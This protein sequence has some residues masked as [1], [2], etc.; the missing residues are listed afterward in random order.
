MRLIIALS[1]ISLLLAPSLSAVDIS[2][3][4]KHQAKNYGPEYFAAIEGEV[5]GQAAPGV[6]AVYINGKKIPV[7]VDLS[8]STTIALKKGQKYLSVETRYKG[9]RFIKKYL[10]IRHP[11]IT[12]PFKIRVSKKEFEKIIAQSKVVRPKPVATTAK[13]KVA[14]PKKKKTH[15]SRKKNKSRPVPRPTPMPEPEIENWLGFEFV[16]ELEPGKLLIVRKVNKKYY[17]AMYDIKTSSWQS[18]SEI[19]AQEFQDLLKKSELL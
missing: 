12:E 15:I 2:E 14:Q 1:L 11:K 13:K 18:L 17:A 4:E 9:L 5:N 6:E 16:A 8:F 10:V 19:T 7:D 3:F